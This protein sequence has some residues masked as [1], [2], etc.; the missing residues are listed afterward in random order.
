M[1]KK[2]IKLGSIKETFLEITP[3]AAQL[4]DPE[5]V[6]NP[7]SVIAKMGQAI[8]SHFLS[9]FFSEYKAK[10]DDNELRNRDFITEK[11]ILIL[12]DLL[13]IVDE[14]KIDEE[15][16]RAMKSIFYVATQKNSEKS[17]EEMAYRMFH[18]AKQLSSEEILILS[19]N[20]AV[21]KNTGKPLARGIVLSSR[22]INDWAQIISE[23]IGHNLPEFVL[24]FENHLVDLQLISSKQFMQNNTELPEHFKPSQYFRL[25][26]LGYKL[27][28]F[29]TKYE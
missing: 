6:S 26:P 25:T 27:C 3:F 2:I 13:R 16:F 23:K 18:I 24:Q 10:V 29:I 9:K 1:N 20:F 7:L 14:G 4:L 8:A 11:P 19:A 15:R 5:I 28:E 21:V 22:H 12:A 17:Q